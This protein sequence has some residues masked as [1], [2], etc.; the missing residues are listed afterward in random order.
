MGRQYKLIQNRKAQFMH[1]FD[2]LRALIKHPLFLPFYAPSLLYSIAQGVLIPVLPLYAASYDVSYSLVGLVLAGDSMGTMLADVP[3][4]VLLRRLGMKRA[5]VL[6]LTVAGLSTAAL[7]LA[8]SIWQVFLLRL[9]TGFGNA[10][11]RVARH[12]YIAEATA[13]GNRGRALSTFGGIFRIGGFI[14]PAV[15]GIVAAAFGLRVP[16]LLF[17]GACALS[18]VAVMRFLHTSETPV[19]QIRA[20]HAP[21]GGHLMRTLRAQYRIL[22]AA[23]T[24]QLF[25]QMVRSGRRVII[26]LYAADVIGLDAQAIGL[27]MSIAAAVEVTM[28]YPAGMLMDQVGRKFAIVPCFFIQAV[29]L[30]LVPFTVS[31][32]GLLFASVVAGFGNGL[33]SGTMMTL[34]AD[35]APQDSRG[36]F[37]G[38]WNLI[39]DV[40]GAAGPLVAGIVADVLVLQAAALVLAGAGFAAATVFA[41]FVPETLQ[42]RRTAP[43]TP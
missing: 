28:F 5:M 22:A 17:G 42:R 25:A 38:V 2:R 36:E 12:A 30:T 18:A 21:A 24:G 33:G 37:L 13:N 43:G 4:G 1:R 19:P 6:G 3:A 23:G 39:G 35:L 40:G 7:F 15:G 27:I 41:R 16:F 20:R 8:G 32:G 9:L 10:S 34:G 14:G 31:F 11:Y 29:G 26:P